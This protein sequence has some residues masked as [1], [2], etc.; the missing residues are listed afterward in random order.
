M[1]AGSP[2]GADGSDLAAAAAAAAGQVIQYTPN[3]NGDFSDYLLQQLT[4][5]MSGP[6]PEGD[7]DFARAFDNLHVNHAAQV[8][9]CPPAFGCALP[10]RAAVHVWDGGVGQCGPGWVAVG[11]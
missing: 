8:R 6:D 11:C 7:A 5:S 4:R 2:D 10:A 1:E 9:A 3:A